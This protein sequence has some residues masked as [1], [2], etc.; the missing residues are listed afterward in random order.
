MTKVH[1]NNVSDRLKATTSFFPDGKGNAQIL[2]VWKKS[3]LFNCNGF[4]VFD[5]KGNLVFRVD[6]Y[7]AGKKS[8]IV[9]MDAA[10]KPL[11]TIRRKVYISPSLSL[12][13]YSLIE[14]WLINIYVC[15][16]WAS[17]TTGWCMM[18]SRPPILDFSRGS[19]WISSTQSVWL[20]SVQEVVLGAAPQC[21]H[22]AAATT[23]CMR[24]RVRTHGDAA[25]CWIKRGH[26]WRRSSRRSQ[27]E[28]WLSASTCSGLLYSLKW[29]H[30][31]PWHLSSF[32]TRC[33]VLLDASPPNHL[34]ISHFS[35]TFLFFF[36]FFGMD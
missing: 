34:S 18:E 36:S 2:T 4:T 29:T 15:R 26:V 9:L 32:W 28:E 27:W 33:S 31:W 24:F 10:G 21:H 23:S 1:P 8:E 30:R 14:F 12:T 22:R 19:K 13:I 5:G 6:N 7:A 17:G 16:D 20:S 25:V 11:L 35:C 3:L